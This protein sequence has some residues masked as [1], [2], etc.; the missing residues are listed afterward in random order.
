MGRPHQS[1]TQP[2]ISSPHSSK[3]QYARQYVRTGSLMASW[4]VALIR[5]FRVLSLKFDALLPGCRR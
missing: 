4:V 3:S 5:L 1:F 2:P